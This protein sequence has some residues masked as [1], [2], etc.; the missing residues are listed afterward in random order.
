MSNNNDL[1]VFENSPRSNLP[2]FPPP[3]V[4]KSSPIKFTACPFCLSNGCTFCA[5]PLSPEEN[6]IDQNLI[7][8]A[9]PPP[10]DTLHEHSPIIPT[11]VFI[12]NLNKK[13]HQSKAKKKEEGVTEAFVKKFNTDFGNSKNLEKAQ[14]LIKK[15]RRI[16][17][18]DPLEPGEH[19]NLPSARMGFCILSG[20][21]H[22]K[23]KKEALDCLLILLKRDDCTRDS[24]HMLVSLAVLCMKN[25]NRELVQAEI[26]DDQ[27]K[28]AEVYN[29]VTELLLRHYTKKHINAITNEL[30]DQLFATANSLKDLNTQGSTRL[31]F[32]AKSALQGILR[33]QDDRKELFEILKTLYHGFGAATSI[34]MNDGASFLRQIEKV[35]KRID[36]KRFSAWYDCMLIMK[37]L[38]KDAYRDLNK[39]SQLQ[40][41]I[42]EGYKMLNWKF[43]YAAI[44]I[45]GEIALKGETPAIRKRAFEGAKQLG[46][47]F[48]GL[49]S[50]ANSFERKRYVNLTPIVHL[51]KPHMKNPNV[52]IRELCAH[53]LIK[54]AKE[55]SDPTIQ[56]KAQRI[57]SGRLQLEQDRQVLDILEEA[58]FLIARKTPTV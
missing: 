8:K 36:F 11:Y 20:L 48:P 23:C 57:L 52:P 9:L 47:A 29:A 16:S 41:I 4:I 37:D 33:L 1:V 50:F 42:A 35:M 46:L 39:L 12:D 54:V 25:M 56:Y 18:L 28:I 15:M 45:L 53:Y 3:I 30:K 19:L 55:S 22:P 51:K 6:T 58:R 31:T 32:E 38:S 7:R 10:Q 34:Y 43:S 26:I 17:G 21:N 5:A 14:R 49:A 27:I 40:V 2:P 24:A 13:N 44:S